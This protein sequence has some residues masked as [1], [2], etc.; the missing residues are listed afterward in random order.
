LQNTGKGID[1]LF[2]FKKSKVEK[3]EKHNFLLPKIEYTAPEL[4]R[5]MNL[6]GPSFGIYSS[7]VN[8]LSFF[9]LFFLAFTV[10]KNLLLI[11]RTISWRT[12]WLVLFLLRLLVFVPRKILVII[13]R[14]LKIFKKEKRKS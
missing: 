10:I 12:G 6:S 8:R 5:A 1:S 11:I 14:L 4:P 13:Y 7:R 2:S 9:P 3:N